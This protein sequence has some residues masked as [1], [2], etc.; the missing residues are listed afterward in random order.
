MIGGAT[1]S[2]LHTALKIAPVYHAPVIHLK[3]ASQNA[4]VAARLMNPNQKEEFVKK[5]SNKYQQLREKNQE[6]TSER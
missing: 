1:T 3:D 5:L 6:K 4:T 2:P